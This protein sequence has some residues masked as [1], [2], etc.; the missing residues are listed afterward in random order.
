MRITRP[1][2]EP[3]TLRETFQGADGARALGRRAAYYS[4]GK[5]PAGLRAEIKPRL[6]R[7]LRY[8]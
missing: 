7:L 4:W 6:I 5:V 2:R 3:T 1:E 8:D